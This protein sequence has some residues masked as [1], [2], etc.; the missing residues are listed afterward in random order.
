MAASMML[1]AEKG[2]IQPL[3]G[4]VPSLHKEG[5]SFSISSLLQCLTEDLKRHQTSFIYYCCSIPDLCL[6]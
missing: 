6:V 2:H 4:M 3:P 1:D 5:Y